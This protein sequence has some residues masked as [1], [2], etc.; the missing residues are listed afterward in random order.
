MKG[1]GREHPGNRDHD[2]L[3]D[4][5]GGALVELHAVELRA[6]V[7]APEQEG[8]C[9]AEMAECEGGLRKTV[10]QAAEHQAQRVRAGLDAPFPG[11]TLEAA[12]ALEC[13]RRRDRIAGMQIDDRVQ[14]L[15]AF[16]E[17]E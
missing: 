7:E 13:R 16:P 10:E 15:R 4:V 17:S 8:Q 11:G 3:A 14:R 9:L 2:I 1:F 5:I 6:A 12:V